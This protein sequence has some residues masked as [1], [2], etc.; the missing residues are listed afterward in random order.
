M[1][2]LGI[3]RTAHPRLLCPSPEQLSRREGRIRSAYEPGHGAD[4]PHAGDP[5]TCWLACAFGRCEH[6]VRCTQGTVAFRP[7]SQV[8]GPVPLGHTA[9]R[10]SGSDFQGL[11]LY[12]TTAVSPV[13]GTVEN[14]P[15]REHKDQVAGCEAALITSSS[16]LNLLP[17]VSGPRST[18]ITTRTRNSIVL[19]I[20]GMAKP[21]FIS[22]AR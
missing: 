14:F 12:Q 1:G 2:A 15:T 21:I 8:V 20:I 18:A 6:A 13:T 16:A 5:R 4:R 9:A 19:I 3:L 17:L 10:H 7:A 22:T 11:R